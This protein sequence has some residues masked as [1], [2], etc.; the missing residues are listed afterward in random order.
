VKPSV[1]AAAAAADQFVQVSNALGSTP[2]ACSAPQLASCF[3]HQQHLAAEYD[4]LQA[5]TVLR[6]R[7]MGEQSIIMATAAP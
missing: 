2:Q 4:V 3:W 6:T 7:T 1:P 5:A